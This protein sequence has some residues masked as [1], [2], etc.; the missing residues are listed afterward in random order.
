MPD[1][2]LVA[3]V[4]TTLVAFA[5]SATYY[6]VLGTQLAT[7][8]PAAAADQPRPATI[9]VELARS[10]VLVAVVAGL[11]VNTGTDDWTGGLVLGLA[12]WI[13]FP[14]VLWAGAMIHEGSP[15]KLA[16]I[17]AGDWLLKLLVVTVIVSVW[18]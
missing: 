2:S 10:L 1:L 11:A 9:V 17:H 3:V 6:M 5:L 14:L 8:S 12:L 18:Q 13:G 4:V 16:A 7:V 15:W